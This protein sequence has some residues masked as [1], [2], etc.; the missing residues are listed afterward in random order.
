MVIGEHGF[1]VRAKSFESRLSEDQRKFASEK[2]AEK[3]CGFSVRKGGTVKKREENGTREKL[4][5]QI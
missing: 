5:D 4:F 2:R 1:M 3:I